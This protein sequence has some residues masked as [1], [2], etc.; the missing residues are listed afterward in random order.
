[1][2]P[3]S[4]QFEE[5]GRCRRGYFVEALGAAQF[6]TAG[7][8]DRLRTFVSEPTDVAAEDSLVLA[9]TDPANPYG[10]ALPWPERGGDEAGHRPGRKA[11]AIVVLVDG[12]LVL[13]LERGGRT[14]LTFSDEGTAPAVRA[15]A[16]AVSSGAL[17]TLSIE[18]VNGDR[19]MNSNLAEPLTAAGFHPTPRGMRGIKCLLPSTRSTCTLRSLIPC[20]FMMW[21]RYLPD[22]NSKSLTK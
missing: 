10:A 6:G 20:C 19:P 9:A 17:G 2:A 3:G 21:C 8:V 11:G 7:S 22:I 18:R 5:S 16:A 14:V 12:R 13:Y 4:E 15:V 1:M